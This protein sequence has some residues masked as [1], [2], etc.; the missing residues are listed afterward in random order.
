MSIEKEVDQSSDSLIVHDLEVI[1]D[2][3]GP[4][5]QTI[6]ASQSA[7]NAYIHV[8]RGDLHRVPRV[9]GDQP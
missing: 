5:I 4:G 3:V 2:I 6:K 8:A 9:G 1:N 7:A